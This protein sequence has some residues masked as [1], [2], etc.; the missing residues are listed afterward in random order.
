VTVNHY[1]QRPLQSTTPCR[2]AV[3]GPLPPFRGGVS[4]YNRL[5]L[6]ALREAGHQVEAYSFKRQYPRWLYPGTTDRDGS[7][8]A[9]DQDVFYDID[10]LNP[11]S[12]SQTASRIV[13]GGPDLVI[14]HW[15]TVFWAPCFASMMN[16]LRRRGIRIAMVCHN[17]V[18]HDAKRIHF[19]LSSGVM[20]LADAF[21]VHS[22]QQV[23]VL[24]QSFANKAVA[25]HAIPAYT[26]YPLPLHTL[27]KR[28]R[29]ELL[30]FGFIRPYKGLDVLLEAM[31][32]ADD[33]EVFL[34]VV[35]ESWENRHRDSSL[36]NRPNIEHH[37]HY[38]TDAAV[39]EYFARADYVV[40]P[41]RAASGSAVA[42]V[43]LHYDKP[44]IASRVG[45]LTDV[46]TDGRTGR[47]VP[48]A[49]AIALADV[50]RNSGRDGAVAM[51]GEVK[52]YKLTHDWHSLGAALVSLAG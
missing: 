31:A 49:D 35:G 3:V 29:L 30:F 17:L 36:I 15:W 10:S 34:T 32:I 28:G 40:L 33:P 13:R 1:L 8:D 48:P 21:L 20:H 22:T 46:V 52:R 18:D 24:R 26:H 14:F 45:G 12:W 23:M 41:Y 9:C 47:L 6:A 44:I 4:Q 37:L 50:I 51:A 16:T 5:L 25:W 38:V 43:A 19:L 42:S 7:V 27:P 39:A 2:L 11:L